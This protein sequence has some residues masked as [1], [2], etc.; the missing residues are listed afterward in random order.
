[1]DSSPSVSSVHE[2]L[3]ARILEWVAIS[4]SRGSSRPRG[5]THVSSIGRQLFTP[6]PPGKAQRLI[7]SN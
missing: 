5:G 1:M 6:E 2:I 4:V 3:Q 7:Q